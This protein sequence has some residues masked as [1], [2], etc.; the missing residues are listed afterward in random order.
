MRRQIQCAAVN[1]CVGFM[2]RLAYRLKE[3]D[4]VINEDLASV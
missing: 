4:G 1:L 3:Q 2:G